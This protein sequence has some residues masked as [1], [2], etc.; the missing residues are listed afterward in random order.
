MTS[1]VFLKTSVARK[2]GVKPK[3]NVKCFQYPIA[4]V[5]HLSNYRYA[6]ASLLRLYFGRALL[7][8]SVV[9]TG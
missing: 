9:R 2:I 4:V 7:L 3:C 6:L 5:Y 1:N 8:S